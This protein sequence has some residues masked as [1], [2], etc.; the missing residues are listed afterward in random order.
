M[1]VDLCCCSRVLS[2]F[3]VVCCCRWRWLSACYGL[4]L[5]LRNC[6]SL[7]L[8]VAVSFRCWLW[9]LL[10][11]GVVCWCCLLFL[12]DVLYCSCQLVLRFCCWLVDVGYCCVFNR[13]S[14]MMVV[15]V[16][17]CLSFVVGC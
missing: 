4:M 14:L 7:L 5:L 13:W 15:V 2:L 1:V 9:L 16:V 6:C 10:F 8:C 12:V 3:S 17:G 11:V